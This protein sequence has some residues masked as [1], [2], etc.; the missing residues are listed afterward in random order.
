MAR[1]TFFTK[2]D[3]LKI[4]NGDIFGF[5]NGKLPKP[6]MLMLDRILK[7]SDKGGKYGKGFIQA[8]LDVN[9][10]HWFFNC[11]FKGDP[12]MPGCLGLDGFWQL[13]GFFLSWIGG[14]G[15]GRALG[16][17]DLK[18]KGQVRPYHDKI[19]YWIDIRKIITKPVYMAWADAVLKIK[20]RTIYFAKDLQVGLFENLTWDFGA[21][22]ALDTF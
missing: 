19:S 3:L 12:V 1:K 2:E 14:K 15:R 8:E 13:V 5:Q 7:I 16:V 9:P 21:D 17:K 18:F 4:A 22:P 10:E 20:D 6:P 11:H